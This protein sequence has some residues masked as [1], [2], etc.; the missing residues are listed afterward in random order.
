MTTYVLRLSRSASPRPSAKPSRDGQALDHTTDEN[1]L[2][3]L[4]SN[5]SNWDQ[6]FT[7]LLI[8]DKKLS[9][10]LAQR[11]SRNSC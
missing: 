11:A 5:A 10:H 2:D 4:K 9:L 7:M 6:G 3:Q 8:G 1:G